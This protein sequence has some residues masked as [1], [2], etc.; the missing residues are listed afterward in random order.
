MFDLWVTTIFYIISKIEQI[1][2]CTLILL[3]ISCFSTDTH[4]FLINVKKIYK[5]Y[6]YLFMYDTHIFLM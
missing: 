2:Q 5:I 1:V 3:Q 6:F 4:R